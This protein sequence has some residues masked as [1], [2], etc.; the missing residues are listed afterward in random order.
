MRTSFDSLDFW[1]DEFLSNSKQIEEYIEDAMNKDRLAASK[2][3]IN[4]LRNYLESINCVLTIKS[5]YK[6]KDASKHQTVNNESLSY[7]R[8]N[9][10][11][12]LEL[13]EMHDL[14]DKASSHESVLVGDYAERLMLH[15][16]PKLIKIKTF[17]KTNYN[18]DSISNLKQFP[19]RLDPITT[20]Y[21]Q[22]VIQ[23]LKKTDNF[24]EILETE[25]YYILDKKEKFINGYFFYQYTLCI[26]N[27][28]RVKADKVIAFSNIDIFDNYAL[29]IRSVDRDINVL[30][31]K[32]KIKIIFDCDIEI[33]GCEFKK[34]SLIL[35]QNIKRFSYSDEYRALMNYIKNNRVSLADILRKDE[36]QFGE[37]TRSLFKLKKETILKRILLSARSVLLKGN[38]GKNVLLYLL[39]S[40]ENKVLERQ[41]P[42]PNDKLLQFSDLILSS[43][44][45]PFDNTPF[46]ASLAGTP[47]DSDILF[48]T[49][50]IRGHECELLKREL[51]IYSNTYRL[52]YCPEEVFA[53]DKEIDDK[54]EKLKRITG[55]YPPFCIESI[56]NKNGDKFYFIK[57]N[58]TKLIEILRKIKSYESK[59]TFVDYSN[60]IDFEIKRNQIIIEDNIKENAIRQM[61][62]N[63]SVFAVY[64]P[65]GTGKSYLCKL[66]LNLLK[67]YNVLFVSSTHASLENLKRKIGP[68][69]GRFETVDKV[70]SC[71]NDFYKK[72]NFLIIDECSTVSNSNMFSILNHTDPDLML[73][74]GD[75][76]QIESID[77]GNWFN[78]LSR[79]LKPESF[80]SLNN[81]FRTHQD[82]LLNLWN[83]V[84][85]IE[86]D[87]HEYLKNYQISKPLDSTFFNIPYKDNSIT[88]CLNYGGVFGINNLNYLMQSKNDG[89]FIKFRQHIYKVGDPV[90]F[91]GIGSFG[92]IF[93]NNLKG[94]IIDVVEDNE[95]VTFDILLYDNLIIPR[96]TGIRNIKYIDGKTKVTFDVYKVKP[97]DLED[98]FIASKVVPFN[99]AYAT[100]IHKAQ[101]LEYDEVRILISDEIE[102]IVTHNIFYTAITRAVK[103]LDIYWSPQCE[104]KIIDSFAVKSFLNDEKIIKNKYIDLR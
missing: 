37:F 90:L 96:N 66:L 69:Y 39:A 16:I 72:F 6:F 13:C 95:K 25:N 57:D 50:D 103:D 45:G 63:R 48:S 15:Y 28:N 35:K 34:L 74:I 18:L 10:Q 31:T 78:L 21:Y 76:Y 92:E 3:I 58:E 55:N 101:G 84:R 7:I 52:L 87:I 14:I 12:F 26:V 104:Q 61:F 98:D 4:I 36:T 29:K 51:D 83:K 60:F 94:K 71:A 91:N 30:G 79:F 99:I 44:C 47:T 42:G 32:T 102:D 23:S 11:K 77:F 24:G 17:L 88:L 41:L 100:S 9:R 85:L 56:I 53:K 80:T 86:S 43:K 22:A 5:N 2:S 70:A 75:T 46:C 64:G 38:K 67:N 93:Y 27:D 82:V 33:R 40:M 97:S 89:K 20:D 1:V 59:K 62:E 73:L 68:N 49:F 19:L 65:A 8:Q 54:I 81:C